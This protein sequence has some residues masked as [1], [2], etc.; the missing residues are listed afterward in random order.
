MIN[1]K[2]ISRPIFLLEKKN[3]S[4]KSK[5]FDFLLTLAFYMCFF[6]AFVIILALVN[7]ILIKYY[8]FDLVKVISGAQSKRIFGKSKYL[9]V[10]LALMIA[11]LLEEMAFRFHLS[12][13]REHLAISSI[14]IAYIYIGSNMY[15]LSLYSYHTWLKIIIILIIIVTYKR[16]FNEKV[17]SFLQKHYT[18]YFYLFALLFAYGHIGVYTKNL[19][20][21][22][23]WLI[24]ILVLPQFMLA[25]LCSYL[26]VVN[27]VVW[28]ILLHVLFNLPMVLKHVV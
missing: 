13:K 24:P 8:N 2:K 7:L 14:A 3:N 23:F 25:L 16:V 6:I 20:E 18:L 15:N 5:L 21:N 9:G 19:P 12:L 4:F 17:I 26:R 1:L 27:G 11:P 22:L 10:I 28:A